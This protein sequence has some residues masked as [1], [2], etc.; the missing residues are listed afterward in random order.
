MSSTIDRVTSTKVNFELIIS[1]QRGAAGE[2]RLRPTV[3]AVLEEDRLAA[4]CVGQGRRGVRCGWKRWACRTLCWLEVC[5]GLRCV[6][7]RSVRAC[8]QRSPGQ[9][10]EYSSSILQSTPGCILTRP[11]FARRRRE[12]FSDCL[13]ES[14]FCTV[15]LL[16]ALSSTGVWY[17]Q[18]Y[19]VASAKCCSR[20]AAAPM[21][22]L[23]GGAL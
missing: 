14:L 7:P 2:R 18:L 4:L 12:L 19:P 21:L 8:G 10:I 13:R 5:V 23:R 9:G 6:D 22:V 16:H 17:L 15:I 11:L 20:P 3:V 1:P